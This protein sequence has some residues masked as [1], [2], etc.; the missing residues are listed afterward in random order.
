MNAA[1][2]VLTMGEMLSFALSTGF[3]ANRSGAG[4]EASYMGWYMVMLATASVVGPAIGSTIYQVDP[5]MVWYAALGVGVAV[6]AGF[7]WLAS[8]DRRP[9]EVHDAPPEWPEAMP[10]LAE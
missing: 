10:Q 8:G 3:V 6:L 2:L 5:N 9:V 1:M 7:L 4:G